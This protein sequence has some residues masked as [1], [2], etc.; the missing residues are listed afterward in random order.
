[1][2]SARYLNVF[3][4]ANFYSLFIKDFCRIVG[5]LTFILKTTSS[6]IIDRNIQVFNEKNK[7]CLVKL[8]LNE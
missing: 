1:M 8:V 4:V 3:E 7:I 2:L 6:I 5:I